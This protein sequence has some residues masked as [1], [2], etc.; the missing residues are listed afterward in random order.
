MTTMDPPRP[1]DSRPRDARKPP[2]FF[3]WLK[4]F[5]QEQDG[6]SSMVRLCAWVCC[7]T[8]CACGV[9]TVLIVWRNPTI[10]P[11]LV[12]ALASVTTT[13]I[14]TGCVALLLRTRAIPGGEEK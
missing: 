10:A 12:F 13:L 9:L 6:G 7:V 1:P 4:D 3:A 2:G 5:V 11:G 14:G 8:G